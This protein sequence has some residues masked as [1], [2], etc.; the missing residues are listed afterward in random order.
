[1]RWINLSEV[2]GSCDYLLLSFLLRQ[3]FEDFPIERILGQAII[4]VLV[5][6]SK[7]LVSSANFA[8]REGRFW[9]V[10]QKILVRG[11]RI[12]RPRG[13]GGHLGWF[14]K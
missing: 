4:G 8:F 11:N 3:C 6:G 5:F 13:G 1:M 2:V 9:P 10:V 12:G 7:E 14:Q